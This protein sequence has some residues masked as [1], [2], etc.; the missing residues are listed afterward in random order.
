MKVYLDTVRRVLETG[1]R[2]PNRTGVD[3]ISTFNVN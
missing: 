1:T 2:R 3:T